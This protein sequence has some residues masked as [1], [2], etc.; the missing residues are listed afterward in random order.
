MNHRDIIHSIALI[1]HK[2]TQI[3]PFSDGNGR[4]SRAFMNR[5]LTRYGLCPIYVKVEDKEQYFSALNIADKT[6]NV[7][8]LESILTS[9]IYRTHAEIYTN[10][11]K[12][13]KRRQRTI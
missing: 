7:S 11:W 1:H 9:N 10:S 3:H 12:E 13:K 8:E 5:Q 4:T 2:L 6:N